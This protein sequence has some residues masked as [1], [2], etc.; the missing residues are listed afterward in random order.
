L[1]HQIP[2]IVVAHFRKKNINDKTF[3]PMKEEFQGTS[4][5]YKI[6]TKVITMSSFTPKDTDKDIIKTEGMY[7]FLT[8]FS[9]QK[10]RDFG[11]TCNYCG[12]IKFNSLSKIYSNSYVLLKQKFGFTDY[13]IV[14][15][16]DKPYWFKK[17]K[18]N[19]RPPIQQSL[20]QVY[21]GKYE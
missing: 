19:L 13:E 21:G 12:V 10:H 1:I 18:S 11:E 17:E 7:E 3:V 6:V 15:E 20:N 14:Q 8:C 2:I 5:L 4:D 16:Q 9:I